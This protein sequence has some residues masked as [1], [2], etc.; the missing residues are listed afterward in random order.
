MDSVKSESDK[1]ITDLKEKHKQ[2]VHEMMLEN[3]AL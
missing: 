3:Q 1:D 2:E